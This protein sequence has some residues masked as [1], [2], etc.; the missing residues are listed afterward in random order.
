[1]IQAQTDRFHN[2][3]CLMAVSPSH[4]DALT[5]RQ[6]AR[7]SR[8]SHPETGGGCGYKLKSI[9]D[10]DLAKLRRAY[11]GCLGTSRR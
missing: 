5:G 4:V 7:A 2:G 1:M 9:I 11:G 6:R 8:G 10:K 3:F